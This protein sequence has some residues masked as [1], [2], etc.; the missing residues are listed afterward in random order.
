MFV[1][2][3]RHEKILFILAI[4]HYHHHQHH[5]KDLHDDRSM[6]V[7]DNNNENYPDWALMNIGP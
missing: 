6:I 3:N 4:D 5:P 1:N 2:E 7:I